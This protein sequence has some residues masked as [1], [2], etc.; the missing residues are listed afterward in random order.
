MP[1]RCRRNA[2]P[3]SSRHSVPSASKAATPPGADAPRTASINASGT[4]SALAAALQRTL[5]ADLVGLAL[6][7][8]AHERARA[9]AAQHLSAC[10]PHGALLRALEQRFERRG[11]AGGRDHAGRAVPRGE[12]N[13]ER[14]LVGSGERYAHVAGG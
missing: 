1:T 11:E 5:H 6:R 12:P 7:L 4:T 13:G 3:T 8:H 9:V 10:S 2:S 14:R